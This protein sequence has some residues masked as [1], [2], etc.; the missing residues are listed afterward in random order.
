GNV[1]IEKRDLIPKR[2]M[3]T[4]KATM[5]ELLTHPANDDYVFVRLL[6]E[7]PVLSPME[8]IRSVYPNAMHVSRDNYLLSSTLNH[9]QNETKNR[10]NRS[11]LELFHAFY[12][13]VKG[14][15]VS[16][17]TEAIF[18]DVLDE[19]LTDENE[20]TQEGKRTYATQ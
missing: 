17:E 16:D 12:E 4:V 18:K 10:R 11:Q 9:E 1:S 7:T 20:S 14:N 3:R 19:L 8:K 13:E 15:P 6:D 2:D 5:E